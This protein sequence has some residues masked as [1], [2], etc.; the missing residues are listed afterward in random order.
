MRQLKRSKSRKLLAT[1]GLEGP[2]EKWLFR[3]QEMKLA[4]RSSTL[5]GLPCGRLGQRGRDY[6]EGV[7]KHFR[8][9]AA[10]VRNTV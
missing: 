3:A 5:V 10:T 4:G 9:D 1:E 7:W 6:L 8:G 2:G